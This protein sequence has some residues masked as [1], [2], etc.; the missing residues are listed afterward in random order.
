LFERGICDSNSWINANSLETFLSEAADYIY[1]TFTEIADRLNALLLEFNIDFKNPVTQLLAC[2][3][4]VVIFV[5]AYIIVKR[6]SVTT[7]KPF[8][9][10]TFQPSY[11]VPDVP[12]HYGRLKPRNIGEQS[13]M[14]T[15]IEYGVTKYS[16]RGPGP[17]P[18]LK[19]FE[20]LS[21]EEAW[22]ELRDSFWETRRESLR[23]FFPDVFEE[24]RY[25]EE[26]YDDYLIY[27]GLKLVFNIPHKEYDL[28]VR[29]QRVI[30]QV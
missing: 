28:W 13:K 5:S 25:W 12:E 14:R 27:M 16:R 30:K 6:R 29:K 15:S 21:I 20:E 22:K 7:E 9:K 17:S 23:R 1:S 8:T 3:I 24:I 4:F 19:R 11:P 10:P 2:F 26:H 18:E